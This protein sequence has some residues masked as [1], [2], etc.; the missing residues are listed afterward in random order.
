MLAV[1]AHI[2]SHTQ[3]RIIEWH[4]PICCTGIYSLC[5]FHMDWIASQESGWYIVYAE[6]Y[7]WNIMP[8]WIL[9]IESAVLNVNMHVRATGVFL[10]SL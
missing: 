2:I 7:D 10:L 1:I 6:Q 9:I 5:A 3:D 4:G 8:Q